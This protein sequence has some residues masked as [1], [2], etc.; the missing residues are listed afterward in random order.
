MGTLSKP[1]AQT[2]APP[3][4]EGTPTGPNLPKWPLVAGFAGYPLWWLLGVG[5]M[6]WPVLAIAMLHYLFTRTK[7]VVPK[8]FGVWLLFLLWMAGSFLAIDSF[9]RA[10]G[11]GYRAVLY[12][13]AAAIFLYVYNARATL[14]PRY[15]AGSLTSFWLV[16]TV[17]GYVGL[18]FPTLSIRTP[19]AYVLPAGLQS[20]ELVQEMVIRRVTQ[21]NPDAWN[22]L[23]PRPSA[24]FLYTNGWGYAYAV[25]LPVVIAYILMVRGERRFW[26][27][28][29]AVPISLAPAFLSLNR[30][31]FIGLG[32]AVAYVGIRAALAGRPAV[33]I[34]LI[35][36]C[37]VGAASTLVLPLEERLSE[38]LE[39][40]S[41]TEDRA[42]LYVETFA[43]TL[44]SP[45]I[46][47]GA[48][49]PS[50]NP[51]IPSL[52][53]QGQLWMVMFSHGFGAVIL[54]VGWFL[55]AY[56]AALKRSDG[57][58]LAAGAGIG[59]TLVAIIFYGI[60]GTN[61]MIAMVLC[62]LVMRPR[63]PDRITA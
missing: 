54:F 26:P 50:E 9:G 51:W 27:L 1:T 48:P 59:Y 53:T 14:T 2:V 32:L 46:G 16:V 34:G 49:R 62:A 10:I 28:V 56:R 41:T 20:N 47:Y 17:G 43:Q 18:A 42:G 35:G 6:I 15:I 13:S 4:E 29:I 21:Y 40:S 11:F 37:L 58:S 19:L 55:I 7:V 12:A 52:G 63:A 33:L 39:T 25:L 23:F 5:D 22:P 61:L 8:G 3:L 31:M 45:I 60:V 30:G 44:E 24:P 57:L 38:R 36:L